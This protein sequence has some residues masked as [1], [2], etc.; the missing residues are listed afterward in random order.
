V[1]VL[2]RQQQLVRLDWETDEAVDLA[3]VEALFAKLQVER[4][5][6]AIV[7]SDYAKGLLTPAFLREVIGF[8]RD[9]GVPVLVDPRASDFARY[10]GATVIKPNLAEVERATGRQLAEGDVQ[11]LDDAARELLRQSDARAMVVTLGQLGLA[12]VTPGGPI[13]L[14]PVMRRNVCDITGA[15]DTVMSVL[16]LGV[17]VGADLLSAAD[18]ANVAGGIA[19]T[20]V[21]TAVVHPAEIAA[22]LLPQPTAKMLSLDDLVERRKWWRQENKRLVLT[23]GCFDLLHVGHVSLLRHAAGLG[24]VL[25]VAINSDASVRRLKGAGRPVVPEAERASVIAALACVDAVVVFD[26]DTPL[27]ALTKLRPDVLVKGADYS[28]EQVVGRE[29]VESYGGGVVLVP[30]VP[31][32]STSAL[33]E[34]IRGSS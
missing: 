5:P 30:L 27:E 6:D 15:G 1:R 11:G 31:D 3:V 22:A 19:V 13:K 32:Y 29:Y 18:L 16:A 28:I 14:L 33:M 8:A 23:N 4:R 20:T 17:A 25:V 10:R 7:L 26:E 24:D 34:K 9:A 12:V 2:A 21:G